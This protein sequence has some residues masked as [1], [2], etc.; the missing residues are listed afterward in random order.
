MQA[1]PA[2]EQPTGIGPGIAISVIDTTIDETDIGRLVGRPLSDTWSGSDMGIVSFQ[3]P[4][5]I[6]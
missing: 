5:S 1:A 6:I 2:V 4:T 3:P